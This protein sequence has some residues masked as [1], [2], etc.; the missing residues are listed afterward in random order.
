MKEWF[1]SELEEAL[2]AS[3]H[4]VQ[5]ILNY[6]ASRGDINMGRIG[7]FGQGSG[8]AI[9]A[10]AATVDKRIFAVDLLDPWGDW[11]DWLKYSRQVPEEERG[12]YL[13]PRFLE[14]VSG[15]DPVSK[16]G[17]ISAA[18]VRVQQLMDDQVTPKEAKAKI[19]SAV[20]PPQ[21]YREYKD[22][23]EH[24]TEW[25]KTGVA[26]WLREQLTASGPD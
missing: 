6:I 2:G 23:M 15:M 12:R 21:V 18:H 5:M 8:G 13:T 11:P 1:V 26:G 17:S 24:A 22:S 4:D 16:I 10:L 7:I 14:S 3:T 9:A 25:Q 20:H 19:A